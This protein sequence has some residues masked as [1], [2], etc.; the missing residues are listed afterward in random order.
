MKQPLFNKVVGYPL[1]VTALLGGSGVAQTPVVDPTL[2]PPLQRMI[3]KTT[4]DQRKAAAAAAA[5]AR[6][7]AAKT[8]P[9]V[10]AAVQGGPVAL[11]AYPPGTIAPPG[12]MNPRGTPDYMGGIVP[13]W[14]RSPIIRKFVDTLPGLGPQNA[15]NLG[16][17]IPIATKNTGTYPG[18]GLL[19]HRRG[20]LHPEAP[21]GPAR[22]QVP[23]LQGPGRRRRQGPLPRARHHRRA[24]PAVRVKFENHAA[25]SAPPAPPSCPW[26]PPPWARARPRAAA[27]SPRTAPSCTSTGA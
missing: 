12:V 15:N 4:N 1:L 6:A 21:L 24:R 25:P 2:P 27:P 3:R 26:T 11:A 18:L 23:R 16:N 17:Y 19:Q 5:A 20:G 14:A 13:N 10:A 9:K 22:H 8:A 7:A